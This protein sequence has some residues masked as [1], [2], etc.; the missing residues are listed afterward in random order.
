MTKLSKQQ[1]L[2]DLHVAFHEAKRHKSKKSYVAK[3]EENLD[4]NLS[5]LCDELFERRYKPQ[6]STCFVIQRPKKREVFAA[7][8][9][10]RIV[11]HLYFG[12]THEMF[13]RTFIEDSYSCIKGKGTDYGISRLR[14]HILGESENYTKRC[15]VQKI[16]IKGYFMHIDRERL[17]VIA[18]STIGKCERK[19]KSPES[20][21]DFDFV[22]YL[23]KSIIENDCTEN[24]IRISGKK[25]YEGLPEYRMMSRTPKNCGL[26][27]GNLT[28]QLFSNVYLNELDNYVKR[29]L[30][31]KHYGRYVDDAYI[32][33]CDKAYLKDCVAKI[34]AFVKDGLGLELQKGK[35]VLRDVRYGVEF[36]GAFIKPFRTYVSNESLRRMRESASESRN[37]GKE[38][39][40]SSATSH[41]GVF[42]HYKAKNVGADFFVKHTI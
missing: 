11:H 33:S 5:E 31:A 38:R 8:F 12:Y 30:K 17:L 6:P 37:H 27:I 40:I 32:V 20:S 13:E 14:H 35:S 34:E 4:G 39:M 41:C 36:L 28:S 16:D 9:R 10:D 24:C 23:T 1:L 7:Q 21:I 2:L 15:Y 42:S 25:E 19:C 22:R 29:T 3:F 18:L 26:P